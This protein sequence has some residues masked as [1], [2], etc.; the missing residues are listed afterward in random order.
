MRERTGQLRLFDFGSQLASRNPRVATRGFSLLEVLVAAVI[1]AGAMAAIIGSISSGQLAAAQMD[2][3]ARACNV[4]ADLLSR[5]A[6]GEF[7]SFPRSGRQ[8]H[9]GVTYQWRIE[10]IE[11]TWHA[12]GDMEPPEALAGA[13]SQGDLRRLRCTV[14]WSARGGTRSMTLERETNVPEQEQEGISP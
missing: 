11:Q 7:G 3:Q 13:P 14:T 1:L 6:A 9:R 12:D 4:A 5:A 2:R 8:Q 10:S